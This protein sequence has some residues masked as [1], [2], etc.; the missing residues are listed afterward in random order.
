MKGFFMGTINVEF[1][2]LVRL[3]TQLVGKF[4]L[5]YGKKFSSKDDVLLP[6]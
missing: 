2:E 4:K 1:E 6:V 5:V 3:C